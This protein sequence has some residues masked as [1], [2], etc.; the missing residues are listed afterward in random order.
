MRRG[1]LAFAAEAVK[2]L[3][4]QSLAAL[5]AANE[6]QFAPPLTASSLRLGSS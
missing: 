5:N 2:G 1:Q 3:R 4:S 6:K